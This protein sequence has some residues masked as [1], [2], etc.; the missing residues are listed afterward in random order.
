MKD[1]KI[2]DKVVMSEGGLERYK[3]TPNNPRDNTVVGEVIEDS[4]R[5]YL[6][7][8]VDWGDYQN[9]YVAEELEYHSEL[10]TILPY[11]IS[12]GSIVVVVNNSVETVTNANVNYE[13]IKEELK[14]EPH[15]V[16]TILNLI[17]RKAAIETFGNGEIT[18]EGNVVKFNGEA[19]NDSLTDKM[20]SV[21]DEGFSVAPWANFYAN[22][23]QNPSY[24]SRQAL[25]NFLE[26]FQAPFTPD[27]CFIAFKRVRN[28]FMD[29]YSGKF[30]N[31]PGTVVEMDRRDVDENNSNTCSAGLHVAAS[32]YLD[33][34][35]S[36]SRAKTVMVKVNP[37]DVVAVPA[38]Y[39]FSKMRVCRY[40][41]LADITVEEM[42]SYEKEAVVDYSWSEDE[43]EK[44]KTNWE[45]GQYIV[46]TESADDITEGE[47]YRILSVDHNDSTVKVVD[48]VEDCVWLN[49][50]GTYY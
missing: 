37:K 19:V 42:S 30:D 6:N 15:D 45:V 9:S 36:A 13:K 11:S 1:F 25:F 35:A 40:E 5:T 17:N 4:Q 20:L 22:L 26:K 33:G 12:Q 47:S 28:D 48:D 39:N 50:D 3:T 7:I 34:Y 10:A 29:I 16:E 31:S 44:V 23:Q 27:G 41:V 21:M 8:R 43:S 14:K 46:A 49:F 18:I 24:N 2:G 38:D 32:S